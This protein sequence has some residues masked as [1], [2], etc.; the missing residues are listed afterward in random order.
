MG[1][2]QPKPLE[3]ITALKDYGV[4]TVRYGDWERRGTV[5]DATFYGHLNHHDAL[6]EAVTDKRALELMVVGRSDLKGPLC[7]GWGDS[8]GIYYLIAYGNAN[9]AGYGEKDVLDRV[10]AGQAP[11]GDARLD[12]D[13]DSIVGN[14]WFWGTEWRNAGTGRDP[15]DQLDTMI[16]VNA[17]LIDVFNW[18]NSNV[19]IGHK[20]WTARKIDPAGFDMF[21]FRRLVNHKYAEHKGIEDEDMIQIVDLTN[22]N[23]PNSGAHAY[24]L[25]GVT[26]RHLERNE[27]IAELIQRFGAVDNRNKGITSSL[28]FNLVNGPLKTT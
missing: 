1:I 4:P 26:G 18:P 19:C 8:D 10:K 16:K 12:S 25:S 14:T 17:A 20:E 2:Y 22:P 9:H 24:A 21:E 5:Y 23:V 3:I 13:K 28:M 6:T 15:Y 11:T 27:D 7:N